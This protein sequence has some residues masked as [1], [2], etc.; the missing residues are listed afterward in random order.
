MITD[1]GRKAIGRSAA[2]MS[3]TLAL[4]AIG[5]KLGDSRSADGQARIEIQHAARLGPPRDALWSIEA[6][7]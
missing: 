4:R 5:G 7:R 1:D 3:C 6:V 2:T